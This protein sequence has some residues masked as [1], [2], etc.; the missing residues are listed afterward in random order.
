MDPANITSLNLA[1]VRAADDEKVRW[2]GAFFDYGGAGASQ[3]AT[4]Y[5]E[6]APGERLGG[7]TDTTEEAQFIVGGSGEIVLGEGTR[8]VA[9]GD[10]V[11]LSEGTWHDLVNT[12]TE[13]LQV[14]GFFAAPAVNQHWDMVM[15]PSN[16][17]VTGSPNAPES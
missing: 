17:R 5:F 14:I 1:E 11:V 15:L 16:T 3:S 9:A 4:I 6:I 10:V 13:A 12:G 8:P 2:T 7:H